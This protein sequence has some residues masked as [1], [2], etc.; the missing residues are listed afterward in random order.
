MLVEGQAWHIYRHT[1]NFVRRVNL[2]AFVVVHLE[3]SVLVLYIV[4]KQDE[5]ANEMDVVNMTSR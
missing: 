3:F 5:R 2:V 1:S 4:V